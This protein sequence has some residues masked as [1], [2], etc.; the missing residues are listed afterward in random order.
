M[1]VRYRVE[2]TQTERE[3]LK[4][5]LDRCKQAARKLKRAQIL[6]AADAAGVGDEGY[7][8]GRGHRLDGL[9]DQAAGKQEATHRQFSTVLRCRCRPGPLP[10][11]HSA[12]LTIR[13][14]GPLTGA[15]AL[16]G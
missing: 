4:G 14:R 13:P 10:D 8:E 7:R 1:N 16:D 5:L 2:L 6:L 15:P 12:M 9:P 3:E 11:S